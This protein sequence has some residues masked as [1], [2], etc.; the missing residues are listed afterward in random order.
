MTLF[1]VN[2]GMQGM[3]LWHGPRGA[4]HPPAPLPPS[5]MWVDPHPG[6][7]SHHRS[8]PA[9]EWEAE[10]FSVTSVSYIKFG[11]MRHPSSLWK[12]WVQERP[13][14]SPPSSYTSNQVW[15]SI[16][17]FVSSWLWTRWSYEVPSYPWCS[18]ILAK[19]RGFPSFLTL[20]HLCC[21]WYYL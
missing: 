20:L 4:E 7:G 15:G 18:V 21:L 2:P 17:V 16:L 10:S 1:T 6:G 12:S 3:Q 14:S 5:P 19:L 13:M 8:G 9:Q 11:S